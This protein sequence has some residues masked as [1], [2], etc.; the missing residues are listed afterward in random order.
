MRVSAGNWWFGRFALM[1]CSVVSLHSCWS[2]AGSCWSCSLP[3]HSKRVLSQ[4][5]FYPVLPSQWE[6]SHKNHMVWYK[7]HI[8]ELRGIKKVV[9]RH[10]R[11]QCSR[12]EL[13]GEGWSKGRIVCVV[14]NWICSHSKR[15]VMTVWPL[16]SWG[17]RIEWVSECWALVRTTCPTQGTQPPLSTPHSRA[18]LPHSWWNPASLWGRNSATLASTPPLPAAAPHLLTSFTYTVEMGS[19]YL[20]SI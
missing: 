16:N 2:P 3:P 11:T 5:A 15:N 7:R 1:R 14:T 18:P 20:F 12:Y 19:H 4:D 8:S 6:K 13:G 9:S 17:M 10:I